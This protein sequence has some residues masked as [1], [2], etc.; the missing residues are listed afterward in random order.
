A[1]GAR[2]EPKPSEACAIGS[3]RE[4]TAAAAPPLDPPELWARFHGLRVGPC[5]C[6]SQVSESPS[7][8]VLVRPKIT[9]PAFF[10]RFT[11]SLS[12]DDGGVSAKKREPRVM[13]TPAIG[14][15]RSFMR[16]GTPLNGPSG[17]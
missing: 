1:A 13:R 4:A 3:M 12:A 9:R 8:Q 2:I 7:S 17:R 15:V 14:E 11:C 16:K 5:S 10:N 6:G